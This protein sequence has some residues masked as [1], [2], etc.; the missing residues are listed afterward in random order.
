M[1]KLDD[2]IKKIDDKIEELRKLKQSKLKRKEKERNDYI[3]ALGIFTEQKIK[4]DPKRAKVFF[5]DFE[6]QPGIANNAN[7]TNRIKTGLEKLGML[8]VEEAVEATKKPKGKKAVDPVINP[9]DPAYT[10]DPAD[11]DDPTYTDDLGA[12][13]DPTDPGDQDDPA[14]PTADPGDQDDPAG[15]T[16]DPGDQSDWAKARQQK[17]EDPDS[18]QI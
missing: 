12:P 13:I 2:D 6:K 18:S 9:D 4:H 3:F 1:T 5:Y 10:D 16:A 8:Q 14:D 11:P 7:L 17:F 15:P